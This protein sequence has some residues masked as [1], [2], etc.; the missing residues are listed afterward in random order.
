MFD[1]VGINVEHDT[2]GSSRGDVHSIRIN[3]V[4]SETSIKENLFV[5]EKRGED[6][7]KYEY[8]SAELKMM[9]GTN[10]P[11]CLVLDTSHFSPKGRYIYQRKISIY[12]NPLNRGRPL[13]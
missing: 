2:Y 3:G 11:I 7:F 6:Y 5:L 10:W 8:F 1:F 13:P 4:S 9:G 12:W